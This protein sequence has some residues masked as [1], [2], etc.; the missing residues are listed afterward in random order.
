MNEQP[1]IA[2][3]SEI[4]DFLD[5]LDDKLEKLSVKTGEAQFK[6][7]IGE[8]H[9]D[10]EVL[11]KQYADIMLDEKNRE[12]IAHW[13]DKAENE[14]LRRRLK[15]FSRAFLSA[16]VENDP[17]L[18]KI[19]DRIEKRIVEFKPKVNGEEISRSEMSRIMES[20]SDRDK[21]KKA[22]YG[23]KE[24]DNQI[25]NDVIRL[26][27][28]RNK[29]ARKL[30][31]K[32]YVELGLELQDI[33]ETEL[34]DLF[35]QVKESTEAK[36]RETLEKCRKDMDLNKI[37]SWD[38]SYYLQTVMPSPAPER[39][40]KSDI[41]P[42]FR[43]SLRDAGGDLDILPIRV[44]QR[45]IPYGGLCMGIKHGE[46]VRI[47]A[48]PKDGLI[49][50][51]AL[52]HEFGHGIHSSLLDT[53]SY[54]VAGGDPAFF[55]EGVAGVFERIVMEPAFLKKRFSLSDQETENVLRI[56]RLQRIRWYRSIAVSCLLEWSVYRGE[57]D[58][59]RKLRELSAEYLGIM[60]PERTGWAGN[61]LYTTHPLYSQNY[62]L[63]DVMAL[64]TIEAFRYKFKKFP[65]PKLFS[66]IVKH[67]IKPAA[68]TPWRQKIINATGNSLTAD[69]LNRY[70]IS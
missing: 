8:E 3:E 35:T 19:A 32:D 55:W 59:R 27:Q 56:A 39:F 18:F 20:E 60:P 58:P 61:T 64:Q 40:P 25:E 6:R 37:E 57:S 9:E 67:Y 54:I 10:M 49:W 53:S 12:T 70:L 15:I 21:R 69:A 36:W 65:G 66:F 33:K 7:L 2:N 51:D 24:L 16:Q 17:N 22:F 44:Y 38:L 42:V 5:K 29:L 34:K 63:M 50:Y 23:G 14:R 62:L 4:K 47:L 68:W 48:N 31:Y 43:N 28:E 45:D 52:F 13:Q 1:E 41:I 26:F 46:D 30:G 11:N